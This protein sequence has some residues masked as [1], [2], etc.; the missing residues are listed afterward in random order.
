MHA[1]I[2][3]D[4]DSDSTMDVQAASRPGRR[5]K[6]KR[7]GAALTELRGQLEGALRAADA[8]DSALSI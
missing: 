1:G 2:F 8:S 6:A 7:L 5:V 4:G 3:A